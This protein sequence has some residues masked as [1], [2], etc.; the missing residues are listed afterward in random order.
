M[1]FIRSGL[2][3]QGSPS[4]RASSGFY[5]SSAAYSRDG[6]YRLHFSSGGLNPQN[7]N[8]KNHGYSVRCVSR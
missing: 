5:W 4:Y 2:Y 7:Y 3:G 8:Y 6:A 1:S